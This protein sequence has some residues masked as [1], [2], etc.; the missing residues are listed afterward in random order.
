LENRIH[1]PDLAKVIDEWKTCSATLGQQVKIVSRRG[2]TEGMAMD[3][4]ANGA[5]IVRTDDGSINKIYYG[6]CFHQPPP[7]K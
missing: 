5:L 4:D 3:V 6:D 1:Q 7:E 2:V